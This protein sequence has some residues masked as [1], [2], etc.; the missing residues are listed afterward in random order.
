MCAISVRYWWFSCDIERWPPESGHINRKVRT[1]L[2]HP[3]ISIEKYG[4]TCLI[5]PTAIQCQKESC[6]SSQLTL[7]ISLNSL[8]D[9][10]S[11]CVRPS[12]LALCWDVEGPSNRKIRHLSS[13]LV[14]PTNK[15]TDRGGWTSDIGQT[16]VFLVL[17]M[18]FTMSD[19]DV[20]EQTH[21][22]S[23]S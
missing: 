8:F 21:N 5:I 2:S 4:Q 7:S 18:A 13:L 22:L 15:I 19:V 23:F 20:E 6:V 9:V 10:R 12:T 1:D 11:A 3:D 17:K 14:A 16:A